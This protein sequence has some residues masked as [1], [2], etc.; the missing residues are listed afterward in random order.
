MALMVGKR[1][2]ILLCCWIAVIA[3]LTALSRLSYMPVRYRAKLFRTRYFFFIETI[4]LIA[5]RYIWQ[6]ALGVRDKGDNTGSSSG[7]ALAVADIARP[8]TRFL[9]LLLLTFM[10]CAQLSYITNLWS[11]DTNPHAFSLLCYVCLAM[12]LNVST[13][14]LLINFIGY[15]GCIKPIRKW[16]KHHRLI[17]SFIYG[18]AVTLVGFYNVSI[19]PTVKQVHVPIRNLPKSMDN[20]HIV[21]ISDIHLGPT[22]GQ[23]RLQEIVDIVNSLRPGEI[24]NT[25]MY[26]I[27]NHLPLLHHHHYYSFLVSGICL[28]M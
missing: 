1:A 23:H 10:T 13:G 27:R 5:N 9:Q 4:L 18:V 19:P 6:H 8:R 14:L 2:V 26:T 3:I 16:P 17:L 21:Q 7:A 22:V 24:L 15:I 20:M 28:E 25:V 12:L 11:I